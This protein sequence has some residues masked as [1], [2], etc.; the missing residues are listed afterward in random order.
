MPAISRTPADYL[1]QAETLIHSSLP[2]SKDAEARVRALVS[3]ATV[4]GNGNKSAIP[5]GFVRWLRTGTGWSPERRDMDD[6]GGGAF[7][8]STGGYF[9]PTEF[10]REVW[11]ALKAVD[12]L[13]DPSVTTIAESN[14]GGPWSHPLADDTENAA[15]KITQNQLSDVTDVPISSLQFPT[16]PTW[17]SGGLK[18]SMEQVQDSA[19]DLVPFL[20]AAFAVRFQ[21]GFSPGIISQLLGAAFVARTSAGATASGQTMAGVTSPQASLGSDDL[22]ATLVNLD[23]SYL[24]GASWLMN[25]STLGSILGLR[26]STTGALIFK[27]HRDPDS[28][29]YQLLG[30]DVRICPA[31]PGLGA[32]NVP[33]LLGNLKRVCIR[34]VKGGTYVTRNGET[35]AEFAQVWFEGFTRADSGILWFGSSTPST[36]NPFVALQNHA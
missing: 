27:G 30:K 7:P 36:P 8:G 5:A 23:E 24:A 34:S 33:V 31:M 20:T 18:I 26:S 11:N 21:R 1:S 16:A 12:D 25:E 6:Q 2:F 22:A 15:E 14:G 17:R 9:T 32:G 29:C 28:G 13:F 35:F 4:A 19:V 10:E 3:L